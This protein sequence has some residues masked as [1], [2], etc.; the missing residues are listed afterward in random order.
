V[1]F[2]VPVASSKWRATAQLGLLRPSRASW[3]SG[4]VDLDANLRHQG[5][6][7]FGVV[8]QV[9]SRSGFTLHPSSLILI[10]HPLPF[11]RAGIGPCVPRM[12][13]PKL[14]CLSR[15]Q[16]RGSSS[17]R[18]VSGSA[19]ARKGGEAGLLIGPGGKRC[20]GRCCRGKVRRSLSGRGSSTHRLW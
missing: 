20:T 16:Q 13:W 7:C 5:G 9:S 14:C 19:T 18:L 1:E 12:F 10:L 3:G 4:S 6:R 15:P 2:P 17:S 11:S 8:R